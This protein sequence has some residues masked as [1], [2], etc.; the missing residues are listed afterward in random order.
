M[1][2]RQAEIDRSITQDQTAEIN[3]GLNKVRLKE[4]VFN[5]NSYHIKEAAFKFPGAPPPAGLSVQTTFRFRVWQD[6][7]A[8]DQVSQFEAR[9]HR[10]CVPC[11]DFR[12]STDM[13]VCVRNGGGP[14]MTNPK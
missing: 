6:K 14:Q 13:I 9:V 12:K 1:P 3:T 2:R 11:A 10:E 7:S 5:I 4:T 8:I